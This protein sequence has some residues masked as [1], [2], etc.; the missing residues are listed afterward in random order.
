MNTNTWF[1]VYFK[2]ALNTFNDLKIARTNKEMEMK[3]A[4]PSNEKK[5][6]KKDCAELYFQQLRVIAEL[7]YI[8]EQYYEI[9]LENVKPENDRGYTQLT[10]VIYKKIHDLPREFCI[11]PY[12]PTTLEKKGIIKTTLQQL[13]SAEKVIKKYIPKENLYY[14]P[15]RNVKPVNYKV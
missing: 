1:S 10:N 9:V 11:Q 12:E 3:S 15:K 2:N 6:L 7:F 4:I 13:C 5:N 14:R 8:I